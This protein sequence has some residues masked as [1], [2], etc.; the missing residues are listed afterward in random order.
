M[1]TQSPFGRAVA[2]RSVSWIFLGLAPAVLSAYL[3]LLVGC[4]AGMPMGGAIAGGVGVTT[5]GQQDIAAARSAIERGE[6]PDPASITVEGFLSE[7]SIEIEPPEDPGLLYATTSTAWNKDFDAFTPLATVQIGF[8][9]TI[10]E[11]TFERPSLNLCVVIDRSGS[12]G[13]FVDVRSATTKLDAVKIA[14]DRLLAQLTGLDQVSIVTFNTR[15]STILE[16]TAG[17]D[18]TSIK[19]ALDE[20]EAGGGTSLVAGLRR[21]YSVVDEHGNTI[22]S[23]RLIVFTDVLLTDPNEDRAI[24]FIET[25]EEYAE[26]NI[27]ATVFGVGVDFGHEVAFEIS[28]VRGANYFFLSDYDRIVSVFD[29]EFDYLV[30]PVAYDV[31]LTLAVPFEF[32]IEDVYGIPVTEPLTHVVDL[33]IPTL[34]L[35][36]REGGG[37]ILVR[38]R[39]GG[40]VDFDTESDVAEIALAYTTPG[41]ETETHPTIRATLPAELDPD[42]AE[43]YFETEGSQRAV[44]LLNTALVLRNACADVFPTDDYYP[45][46]EDWE[47]AATRLTEFLPY[48]DTLAEGLEDSVSPTSRSLSDERALVEQL[49]NNLY[50]F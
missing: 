27:G 16:A 38:V 47:R 24:D 41:G 40:A 29:E 9:T 45:Y 11:E 26:D 39:A 34:F 32:D 15:S 31:E 43:S 10:D 35:S 46:Y 49:L 36:G 18:L 12:M 25:M 4:G 19:N 50:R 2:V 44:L 30:T 22:R 7:H 37:A 21:G 20:V 33:S 6:I 1:K 3:M 13:D 17:N 42:A 14:I 48:F 5:G 23:D 8:G 28:Q